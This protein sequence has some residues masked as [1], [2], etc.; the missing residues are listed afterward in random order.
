MTVVDRW[1][2]RRDLTQ[3]TAVHTA[4]GLTDA[5]I[6]QNVIK[7]TRRF[8]STL[9]TPQC[10]TL[11]ERY[12]R[13]ESNNHL[14]PHRQVPQG[15]RQG[16]LLKANYNRSNDTKQIRVSTVDILDQAILDQVL[17]RHDPCGESEPKVTVNNLTQNR[18]V[19]QWERGMTWLTGR[20]YSR[21]QKLH[22]LRLT[23]L[24]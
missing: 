3:H 13:R 15:N 6:Q 16:V 9:S 2:I 7:D 10:E 8:E 18:Q 24:R 22:L 20:H 21:D 23:T 11:Q 1:G 5:N 14:N 12:R 17:T 19:P 4:L